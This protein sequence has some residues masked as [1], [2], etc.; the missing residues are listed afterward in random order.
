MQVPRASIS[1]SCAGAVGEVAERA[2]EPVEF[3]DPDRG[4]LRPLKRELLFDQLIRTVT[5]LLVQ[6]VGERAVALGAV[7]DDGGR[8]AVRGP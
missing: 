8:L 2:M 3:I 7:T 4:A 5:L 6:D 1:R